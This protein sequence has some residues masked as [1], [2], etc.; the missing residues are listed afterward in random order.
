M[1]S[2]GWW[3]NLLVLAGSQ[4]DGGCILT[5]GSVISM[6]I[7]R[8]LLLR[9]YWLLKCAEEGHVILAYS[10]A[11]TSSMVLTDFSEEIKKCSHTVHSE[12]GTEIFQP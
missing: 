6:V 3:G 11:K 10:L 8:K 7:G 5:H 9:T 1:Y 2:M 12:D 4:S